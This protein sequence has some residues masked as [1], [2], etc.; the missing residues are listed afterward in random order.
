M[1]RRAGTS[2]CYSGRAQTAARGA[3][4]RARRQRRANTS[5]FCSMRARTAVSGTEMSAF[6][7]EM[8]VISRWWSGC[9]RTVALILMTSG[10]DDWCKCGKKTNYIVLQIRSD[11]LA[12]YPTLVAVSVLVAC[13]PPPPNASNAKT[14]T[15][16]TVAYA[17]NPTR[18]T[19]VLPHTVNP[20][21]ES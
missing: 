5:I 8:G 12:I 17:A 7:Q 1:R 19:R 9:T 20:T 18:A 4:V 2:R 11:G 21:S 14:Y 16:I 10:S 3:S 15:C 13:G 6:G